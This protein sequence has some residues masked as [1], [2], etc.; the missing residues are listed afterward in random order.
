MNEV[1]PDFFA[2]LGCTQQVARE[3]L[4]FPRSLI[5]PGWR[6]KIDVLIRTGVHSLRWFPRFLTRV[7]ALISMFRDEV[8]RASNHQPPPSQ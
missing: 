3:P 1:L 2:Q 8:T 4:L 6:H 5:I 7:K